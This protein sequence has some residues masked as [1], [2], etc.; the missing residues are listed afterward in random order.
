M[1][2]QGLV[3][4]CAAVGHAEEL[5]VRHHAE[6]RGEGLA[7]YVEADPPP[8]PDGQLIVAP[9]RRRNSVSC[10]AKGKDDDQDKETGEGSASFTIAS[11]FRS[12]LLTFGASRG[13]AFRLKRSSREVTRY[14]ERRARVRPAT[15]AR[16]RYRLLSCF[17][18]C[19]VLPERRGGVRKSALRPWL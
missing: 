2:G 4:R 13:T 17:C 7:I 5:P 1:E 10:Y 12:F 11:I 3:R 16:R 9:T 8:V 19:Q 14:F 15:S 18:R 6:D